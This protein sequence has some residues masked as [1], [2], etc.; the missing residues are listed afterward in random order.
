MTTVSVARWSMMKKLANKI[1][2][3][4][5][6]TEDKAQGNTEE[7]DMVRFNLLVKGKE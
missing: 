4:S 6:V 5:F 7:N 2:L 3:S 1:F